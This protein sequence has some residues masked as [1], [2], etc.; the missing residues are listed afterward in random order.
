MQIFYLHHH[1]LMVCFEKHNLEQDY[2]LGSNGFWLIIISTHMN[3]NLVLRTII[4]QH[5]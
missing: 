1:P 4:L 3:W 2:G 5:A